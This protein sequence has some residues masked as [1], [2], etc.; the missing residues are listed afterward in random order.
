VLKI[1]VVGSLGFCRISDYFEKH[2][3]N[4]NG[5]LD[6]VT[7][8]HSIERNALYNKADKHCYI[9]GC[10]NNIAWLQQHVFDDSNFIW[11]NNKIVLT[12]RST[13]LNSKRPVEHLATGWFWGTERKENIKI[14]AHIFHA[15]NQCSEKWLT[16]CF[17]LDR[18]LQPGLLSLPYE[19]SSR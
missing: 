14:I 8:I 12:T 2:N 5:N 6:S 3:F 11:F 9:T 7:R 18:V 19:S 13:L 17:W 10:I 15:W 1:K 4:R 16:Y